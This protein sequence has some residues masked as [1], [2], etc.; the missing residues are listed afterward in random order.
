MVSD[1]SIWFLRLTCFASL[2]SSL[3]Q[4]NLD[5][6]WFNDH[7]LS[8]SLRFNECFPFINE[9][10]CRC[11]SFFWYLYGLLGITPPLPVVCPLVLS[12]CHCT[13]NTMLQHCVFLRVFASIDIF[14]HVAAPAIVYGHLVIFMSMIIFV[15]VTCIDEPIL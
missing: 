11:D 2:R 6:E 10:F 14:L 12:L 1:Y 4:S 9:I 15:A 5:N 3:N 13:Y 7:R 8:H